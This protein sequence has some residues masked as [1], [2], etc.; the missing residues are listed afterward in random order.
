MIIKK[1]IIF[2]FTFL[3][4]MWL[5][6]NDDNKLHIQKKREEL[7][8]IIKLPLFVSIL[9]LLII[10][11]DTRICLDSW[12]KLLA[13]LVPNDLHENVKSLPLVN[14]IP[15][16]TPINSQNIETGLPPF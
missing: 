2:L 3:V 7:Y 6:N 12:E 15:Q 16:P 10:E 1:I 11:I 5:Q 9:V 13:N 4:I 14:N 8:D